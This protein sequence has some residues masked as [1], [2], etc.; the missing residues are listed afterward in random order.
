MPWHQTDQSAAPKVALGSP[1]PSERDQPAPVLKTV[2]GTFQRD[3]VQPW[4]RRCTKR[5]PSSNTLHCIRPI[6]DPPATHVFGHRANDEL[7]EPVVSDR[8]GLCDKP[9]DRAQKA[10]RCCARDARAGAGGHDRA[11]RRQPRR[12]AGSRLSRP[13]PRG[14]RFALS[15]GAQAPAPSRP[16]SRLQL[17]RGRLARGGSCWRDP[18]ADELTG[19]L[20]GI[21]P[22]REDGS[23][24]VFGS[25]RV[26]QSGPAWND[27]LP[28]TSTSTVT[29]A[30]VWAPRSRLALLPT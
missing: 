13:R 3:G 6:L 24:P 8:I 28:S 22:A 19:A 5:S 15:S 4:T 21:F 14:G 12:T 1:E 18:A 11:C 25:Y 29:R 20:V 17:V 30:R 7:A 23:R 9:A 26:F 27:M 10:R 16:L 2:A